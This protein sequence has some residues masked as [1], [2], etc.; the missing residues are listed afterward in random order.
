V[1]LAAWDAGTDSGATYRAADRET[2]PRARIARLTG[3]P[4]AASGQVR[5]FGTFTFTRIQYVPSTPCSASSAIE[6]TQP[7]V[8]RCRSARGE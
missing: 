1:E 5:P 3:Y 2:V 4:V 8:S 6:A 7:S